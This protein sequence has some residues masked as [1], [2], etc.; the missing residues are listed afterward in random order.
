MEDTTSKLIKA[1]RVRVN[2]KKKFINQDSNESKIRWKFGVFACMYSDEKSQLKI[3]DN[4]T[5]LNLKLKF[6]ESEIH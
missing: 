1:R 2:L 6:I 4:W 5:S 3:R